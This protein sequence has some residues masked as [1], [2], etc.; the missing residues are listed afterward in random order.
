M[1]HLLRLL[2][3]RAIWAWAR[4]RARARA[5]SKCKSIIELQF[6]L[7]TKQIECW[8][9][10]ESENNARAITARTEKN[11]AAI[12]KRTNKLH[13]F[14]FIFALASCDCHTHNRSTAIVDGLMR[15]SDSADKLYDYLAAN[16]ECGARKVTDT[17]IVVQLKAIPQFM[18]VSFVRIIQFPTSP[19]TVSLSLSIEMENEFSSLHNA[20][21]PKW[22][23]R[24]TEKRR[25]SN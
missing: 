16:E 13:P 8:N 14:K 25:K 23:Q 4:A 24:T 7:Q 17:A 9:R 19:H 22:K 18:V 12:E 20:P 6:L 5:C 21:N 15:R 11:G 10:N 3:T 2:N 1:N